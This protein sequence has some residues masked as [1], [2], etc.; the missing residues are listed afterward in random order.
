MER[1]QAGVMV[2]IEEKWYGH[3]G[4]HTD[5]NAGVWVPDVEAFIAALQEVSKK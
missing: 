1:S 3:E 4:W 2:F 5:P